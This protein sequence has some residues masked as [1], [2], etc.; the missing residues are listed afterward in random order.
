MPT[1]D[2]DDEIIIIRRT[3]AV[4]TLRTIAGSNGEALDP[5]E[6]GELREAANIVDA[7]GRPTLY[8]RMRTLYLLGKY[9]F[10]K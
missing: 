10:P 5:S 9:V 4:T 7:G 8:Q 3:Q 2:D 1:D 6:Q